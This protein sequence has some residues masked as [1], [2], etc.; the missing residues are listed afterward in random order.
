[1]SLTYL[2]FIGD[3]WARGFDHAS[4]LN[5]AERRITNGLPKLHLVSEAAYNLICQGLHLDMEQNIG[6]L[7]PT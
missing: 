1:M 3:C 7:Q 4:Y 2:D 6:T 5:C